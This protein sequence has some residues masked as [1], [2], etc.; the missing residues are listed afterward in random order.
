MAF[1]Y[2][3]FEELLDLELRQTLPL[4]EGPPALG[5]APRHLGEP[6]LLAPGDHGRGALEVDRLGHFMISEVY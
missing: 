3:V 1:T 4:R 6:A 5:G 2:L